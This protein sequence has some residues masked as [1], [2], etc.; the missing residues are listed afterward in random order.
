[1]GDDYLPI[2]EVPSLKDFFTGQG[3]SMKESFNAFLRTTGRDPGPMWQQVGALSSPFPSDSSSDRRC[4]TDWQ[5]RHQ[6]R[7]GLIWFGFC[8][9]F[10][11]PWL[12]GFFG[13][14]FNTGL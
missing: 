5:H 1:M 3:L 4:A 2:W 10:F 7:T 9:F 6:L 13:F 8:D 14:H 12:N 11:F